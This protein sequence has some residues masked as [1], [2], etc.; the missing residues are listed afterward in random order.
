VEL[1]LEP[2]AVP[3]ASVVVVAAA[4]RAQVPSGWEQFQMDSVD[5]ASLVA[6]SV[7]SA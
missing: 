7:E 4:A 6:E 3:R 5:L 2:P 1:A